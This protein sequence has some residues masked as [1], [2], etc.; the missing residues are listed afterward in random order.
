ML[1]ID[2]GRMVRVNKLLRLAIS[3]ILRKFWGAE[4]VAITLTAV[5]TSPDLYDARVSYSVLTD[6]KAAAV[7]FFRKHVGMIS[8]AVARE[9]TLK[10]TP[11]LHFVYDP[12]LKNAAAVERVMIELEAPAKKLPAIKKTSRKAVKKSKKNAE[13]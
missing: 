10:R 4:T 8:K 9:V 13:D 5:D 7:A 11:R 3:D 2:K 6:D 12:T 1:E